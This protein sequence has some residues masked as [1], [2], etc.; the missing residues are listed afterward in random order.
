MF[1]DEK[2]YNSKFMFKNGEILEAVTPGSAFLSVEEAVLFKNS[3][4]NIVFI[5]W[6]EVVTFVAEPVNE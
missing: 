5:R 2:F 4:G 6:S 3:T 1:E